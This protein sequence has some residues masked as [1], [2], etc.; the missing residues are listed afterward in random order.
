MLFRS[1]YQRMAEMIRTLVQP[2]P[3]IAVH[4]SRAGEEPPPN[5]DLHFAGPQDFDAAARQI[6][7]E[8][9]RRGVLIQPSGTK[10]TIQYSI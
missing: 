7:E 1:N 4:M 9:K 8:L 6:L 5:T 3:V 10:S 2:A